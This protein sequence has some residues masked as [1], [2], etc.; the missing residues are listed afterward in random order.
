MMSLRFGSTIWLLILFLLLVVLRL[1]GC[2][3]YVDL[4]DLG[5]M[6]EVFYIVIM[7][8]SMSIC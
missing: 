4:F 5:F 6:F 3:M 2:F 8:N 7:I 1:V